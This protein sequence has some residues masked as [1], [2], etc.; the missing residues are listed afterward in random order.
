[1]A[2]TDPTQESET[3]DQ[4]QT[5]EGNT[6]RLPPIHRPG[7]PEIRRKIVSGEFTDLE[8]AA[9]LLG[10]PDPDLDTLSLELVAEETGYTV[11]ELKARAQELR[12]DMRD[13]AT[14]RE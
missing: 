8:Y 14:T 3:D 7:G 10:D 6:G 11:E 1:M 5:D 4:P 12:E 13:T 2:D 9:V